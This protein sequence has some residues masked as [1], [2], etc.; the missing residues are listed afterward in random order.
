MINNMYTYDK[1]INSLHTSI[2]YKS[3]KIPT[4]PYHHLINTCV[5][6]H[7]CVFL[8]R[9]VSLFRPLQQQSNLI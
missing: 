8:Y 2:N 4:N 3:F 7:V 9:D 6:T 5:Y 1:L